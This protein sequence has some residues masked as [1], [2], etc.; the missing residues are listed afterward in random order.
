MDLFLVYCSIQPPQGQET[1]WNKH[2]R[3][4]TQNNQFLK[5][6]NLMLISYVFFF[7]DM[8]QKIALRT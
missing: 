8:A 4:M 5:L 3:P 1:M 6:E 7:I 2:S